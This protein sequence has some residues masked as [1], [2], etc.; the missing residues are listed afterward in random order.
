MTEQQYKDLLHTHGKEA[1]SAM[2]KADIRHRVP[3]PYASIYCKQF[4]DAK[5]LADFLEYV[6]KQMRR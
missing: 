4:D 1:F 6:A 3:E 2:A 5:Q